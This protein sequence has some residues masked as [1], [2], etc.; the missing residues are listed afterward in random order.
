M[1]LELVP[2]SSSSNFATW[3]KVLTAR[4]HGQS[5]GETRT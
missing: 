1:E 5:S 3:E 2:E 4:L